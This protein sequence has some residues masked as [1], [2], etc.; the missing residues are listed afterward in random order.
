MPNSNNSI[1]AAP[2]EACW[3]WGFPVPSSPR[4][5]RA[6]LRLLRPA[7]VILFRRNIA[8]PEQTRAL[9]N[10]ATGLCA[11]H[12]VR[13]VDVEGGTV[14]RLARCTRAAAFRA[15][16]GR[17]GPPNRKP[18]LGPPVRRTGRSRRARL[19]LQHHA[20]AG[21]RPGAARIGRG[22]GDTLGGAR[23]PRTW[24]SSRANFMPGWRRNA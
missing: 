18:A 15:G 23:A 5:E 9:L 10:E 4:S 3:W 22:D 12:S 17:G 20:R 16:R 13:Y 6:W 21:G 11:R 1:C 19:R 7:G 14:N 24:W 2:W 8:D